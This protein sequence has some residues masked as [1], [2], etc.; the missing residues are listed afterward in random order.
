[1]AVPVCERDR[2]Y[3]VPDAPSAAQALPETSMV[4]VRTRF[5]PSPTGSMHLGNVRTAVFNWLFARHHDGAFILRI[6]D[7]DVERNREG[8]EEGIFRDLRWLGLEWDE[9]PDV[10]GPVGPYRQSE[11]TALYRRAAEALVESGRAYP[12]YCTPEEL[13][14]ESERVGEGRTV[15]RYSGRCRK[16]TEEERHQREVEGRTSS[17]RIAIPDGADIEVVDEVRGPIAF[18]TSEIDDFIIL[19]SDGRPT[20]NFAVVVD[21]AE[22]SIS[23][24]I[25]GAGHLSNTPKQAVLFDA[26]GV[27]RPRFIHLPTVLSPEGGKLSKREDSAAVSALREAGYHPDGVVN[28]LSLLGWSSP[29]EEEVLDRHELIDRISIERL[30]ASDTE[31]DAEKLRWLSGQ[32]LRRSDPSEIVEQARGHLGPDAPVLSNEE[33]ARALAVLL[34]RIQILDELPAEMARI[35]PGEEALARAR[36][37]LRTRSEA[38]PVLEAVRARIREVEPWEPE[39]IMGA[40]RKG[41]E[42]A[43]ARGRALFH[44]VREALTAA[45][46]GPDLGAVIWAI[47]RSETI[48]RLGS[49]FAEA[50]V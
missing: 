25:R 47:G 19:R 28:Y 44:P 11:R 36:R 41:G 12:C 35:H 30:G 10:G 26:L 18:P 38:R 34:E 27:D 50:S 23:H 3:A 17:V 22:M 37:E 1:M 49:V 21:D 42:D 48:R 2:R 14:E 29:D 32:H 33:L 9:G 43:D 31:Y 24:V 46:S 13:E 6:E 5:A 39:T 45:T 16:L 15:L 4:Q 40:V 7:T 8:S 20:Y